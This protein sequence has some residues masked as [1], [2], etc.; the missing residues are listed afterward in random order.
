MER[1]NILIFMTDH[2]RADTVLPEHPARTPHLVQ[3]ARQGV[4]FT[5]TFCPSPHCCPSRATFFTGLY[6]S[7]HGVWNNVCNRQA[8]SQR[9]TRSS[10][11]ISQSPW[12]RTGRPRHSGDS[13]ESF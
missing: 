6:P 9:T 12:H 5:D 2:Q 4:T 13:K 1:P 7:R 10:T 3:F 8:Q 11:A